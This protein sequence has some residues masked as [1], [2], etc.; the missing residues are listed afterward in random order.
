VK[1]DLVRETVA[2]NG[3]D[4]GKEQKKILF[5]KKKKLHCTFSQVNDF[6]FFKNKNLLELVW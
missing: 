1:E 3:Y 2:N 6:N 4:L 5:Y